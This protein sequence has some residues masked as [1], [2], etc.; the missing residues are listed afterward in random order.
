MAPPR[1]VI[2][3]LAGPR[4]SAEE[5][6]LWRKCPPLGAILFARN[7]QDPA[8]LRALTAEIRDVLG[9]AA[10]ILIDQEGGRVARLKPPHWE[11]FPAAARFEALPEM[12]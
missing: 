4:L 2:L 3:G 8:Q 6:A 1:A 12:T 5:A 7:I 11:A 9:E 10:P